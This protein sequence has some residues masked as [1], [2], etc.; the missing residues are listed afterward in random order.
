[1]SLT[2][3]LSLGLGVLL[4]GLSACQP[5]ALTP[6]PDV[7][8]PLPNGLATPTSAAT[9]LAP[10]ALRAAA[11]AQADLA[12]RLGPSTEAV[13][14][15]HIESAQWPDTCLGLPAPD[16]ACAEMMV[17][18][19]RVVLEAKGQTVTYRT[20]LEGDNVRAEDLR[21]PPSPANVP[22]VE[23]ARRYL[24]EHLGLSDP[25]AI[26]VVGAEEVTWPDACL[27]AARPDE[28][29]AQVLT[30]GYRITLEVQG[31]RY[32]LHTNQN[33]SAIRLVESLPHGSAQPLVRWQR[34]SE[35]ACL[36]AE[37]NLQGLT[38]GACGA[39]AQRWAFKSP[40]QAAE[41]S[42]FVQ[43][44]APFEAE[45]ALGWVSLAG[46]GSQKATPAEQ[47]SL[48]AWVAAQVAAAQNVEFEGGLGLVLSW[49]R[50]G[51]I[52]GL[53]Q[54]LRV[55][56]SGWAEVY[57][58]RNSQ[59]APTLITRQ[60]LTAKELET[61]YGWVDGLQPL[62][63]AFEQPYADG[64]AFQLAFNGRG[65]LVADATTQKA[66]WDWAQ[67]VFQRLMSP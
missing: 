47:R 13:S 4:L 62:S 16:E 27:G 26:T 41:L 52:A 30:P 66:L 54:I 10:T 36:S 24:A 8:T 53:C 7:K 60:R 2:K 23:A 43:T 20:N 45:T 17:E 29:C 28:M 37:V 48:A 25:L 12:A 14:I 33:G 34:Q 3:W 11:A 57:D 22:A 58:C 39:A 55:Y 61:L 49:Q 40:E 31:T 9:P 63:Q 15:L 67:A 32:T 44:Y 21:V 6:T 5:L 38:Y 65:A 51:G 56:E 19:F 42:Q 35:S 59:S 18:G 50:S 64:F 1:M 46:K